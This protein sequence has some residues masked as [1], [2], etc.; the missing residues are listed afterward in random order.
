MDD[1]EKLAGDMENA[2]SKDNGNDNEIK[3]MVSKS[4]QTD[5]V[6]IID[7]L[8]EEVLKDPDLQKALKMCINYLKV[9]SKIVSENV[10]QNEE[11]PMTASQTELMENNWSFA[12]CSN[13]SQNLSQIK[14][15]QDF[16]DRSVDQFLKKLEVQSNIFEIPEILLTYT[17]KAE[18]NSVDQDKIFTIYTSNDNNLIGEVL[19]RVLKSINKELASNEQIDESSNSKDISSEDE[20]LECECES[21]EELFCSE[22]FNNEASK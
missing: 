19:K 22:F 20:K 15:E 2:N 13:G 21:A 1:T 10:V 4:S 8:S 18:P 11:I 3:E 7:I 14:L 16:I 5:D 17:N 6:S 12:S 9:E